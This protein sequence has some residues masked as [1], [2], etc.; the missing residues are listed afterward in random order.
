MRSM[1]GFAARE[2]RDESVT[3]RWELRSVNGRGL[4]LRWRGPEGREGVE[5]KCRA[6]AVEGLTR[7][8]LNAALRL[9]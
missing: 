1:T 9:S 4:D 7:G 2:G 3:W 6:A 8:A 5:A